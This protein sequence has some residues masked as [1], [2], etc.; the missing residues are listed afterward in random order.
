MERVEKQCDK[1]K[2]LHEELDEVTQVF[3]AAKRRKAEVSEKLRNVECEKIAL[4]DRL[5]SL[6]NDLSRN[7]H[8]ESATWVLRVVVGSTVILEYSAAF[9][10]QQK[11]H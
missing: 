1:L 7:W 3:D 4:A 6:I 2:R 11:S 10:Y 5:D 8:L 9:K